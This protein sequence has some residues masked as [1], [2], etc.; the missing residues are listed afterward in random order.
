MIPI[1]AASYRRRDREICQ[2]TP[3]NE[4]FLDVGVQSDHGGTHGP[5][6]E[7]TRTPHHISGPTGY[8]YLVES[9]IVIESG[10]VRSW[11][12]PCRIVVQPIVLVPPL[13]LWSLAPCPNLVIAASFLLQSCRRLVRYV[14]ACGH[15]VI[16]ARGATRLAWVMGLP[17]RM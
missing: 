3:L 15:R 10:V 8:R 9:G 5:Y 14:M 2:L 17:S 12:G 16:N 11:R 4:L 1:W 6:R 13:A 7:R